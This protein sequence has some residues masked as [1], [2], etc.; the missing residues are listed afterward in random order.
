MPE[1]FEVIPEMN[2][3]QSLP[4]YAPDQGAL[5]DQQARA[6][7]CD[8]AQHLPKGELLSTQDLFAPMEQGH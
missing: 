6:L 2:E 8:A 3:S 1:V 4:A 7:R 5:T